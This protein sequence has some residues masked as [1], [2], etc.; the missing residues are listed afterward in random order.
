[1]SKCLLTIDHLSELIPYF[2]SK[3]YSV[4]LTHGAFDLFHSGHLELIKRTNSIADI[5]IVGLESDDSMCIYKNIN[6]PIVDQFNR[7][8]ILASLVEVDY[9]F[10][11]PP[12]YLIGRS[13][14]IYD[15]LKPDFVTHGA[16]FGMPKN[17]YDKAEQEYGVKFINLFEG[18]EPP[19]RTS[20]II[21]Q[22]QNSI[23]DS[24]M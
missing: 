8:E 18:S 22:I 4:A 23:L 2:K 19:Y 12:E 17:L 15:E 14:N 6:R 13:R 9:T 7:E 5:V 16:D 24:L 21:Q 11:K 20:K 1:M 10:I 3:G